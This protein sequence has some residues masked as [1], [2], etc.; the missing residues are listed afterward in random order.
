M[1]FFYV[2]YDLY[3]TYLPGFPNAN[4]DKGFLAAALHGKGN[5]VCNVAECPER[6]EQCRHTHR[7]LINGAHDLCAIKLRSR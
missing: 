3:S 2:R 1:Q 6:L 7:S 5:V 4:S